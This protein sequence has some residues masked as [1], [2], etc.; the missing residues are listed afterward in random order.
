MK[1]GQVTPDMTLF[2]VCDAIR[3]FPDSH[4][5]IWRKRLDELRSQGRD[6]EAAW[7]ETAFP[8]YMSAAA[9]KAHEATGDMITRMFGDLGIGTP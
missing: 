7:I 6:D 5:D 3:I 2:Q 9:T 8:E 1:I 4:P